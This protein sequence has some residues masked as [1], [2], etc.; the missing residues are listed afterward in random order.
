[1]E[2]VVVVVERQKNDAAE[3]R[4]SARRWPV[5]HPLVPVKT[6]EQQSVM[7]LLRTRLLLICQRTRLSNTIRGHMAEYGCS[8]PQTGQSAAKNKCIAM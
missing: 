6:G 3:L 8:P 4:R 5:D 1:M 7:V 2:Q